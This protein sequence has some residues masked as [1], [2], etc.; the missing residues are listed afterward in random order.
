MPASLQERASSQVHMHGFVPDLNLLFSSVLLTIA[1][2][3]YGAGVKGKVNQSMAHGVPVV[4]TSIA[5]EGMHLVHN[6]DVLIADTATD[7]AQAIVNL[8]DD[9]ALWERIVDGGRRNIEKHFSFAAVEKK[10]FAALGSALFFSK[11]IARP[12]VRRPAAPYRLGEPVLFGETGNS[13]NYT[14]L[15]WSHA[16]G[17]SRWMVGKKASLDFQIAAA[18]KP[19]KVKIIVYPFLAP[20]INQ[21]QRLVITTAFRRSPV[22][23]TAES[24]ARSIEVEF[25][26]DVQV[27][28]ETDLT[29]TFQCPDAIAPSALGC[30]S[31]LRELSFAFLEL[32]ITD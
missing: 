9:Q 31:D 22:E 12:L 25:N 8:H 15:G 1:P 13:Q 3:R 29:L 10:L 7:F 6:Q 30:S 23:I 20:P 28:G 26:L 19:S 27:S 21:R 5:A 2:L 14:G 24:P 4:A 11:G 18:S 32:T 16:E 17:A